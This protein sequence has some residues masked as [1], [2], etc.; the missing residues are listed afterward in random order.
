VKWGIKLGFFVGEKKEQKWR[1]NS[2]LAQKLLRNVLGIYLVFAIMATSVQLFLEFSNEKSNQSKQVSHLIKIFEKNLSTAMWDMDDVQVLSVIDGLLLN[3]EIIGLSI[4]W[5]VDNEVIQYGSIIDESGELQYIAPPFDNKL[6]PFKNNIFTEVYVKAFDI[7]YEFAGKK[8][9]VGRAKIYSSS[10]L[11]LERTSYTLYITVVNAALKTLFLYLVFQLILNRLVSLPLCKLTKEVNE[12]N[13]ENKK[14]TEDKDANKNSHELYTLMESFKQM[15]HSIQKKNSIIDQHKNKLEETV[16]QR[17]KE[18]SAQSEVLKRKSRLLSEQSAELT[19]TMQALARASESKSLFLA[20]MS[21]EIRTPLN[22]IMGMTEFL[23][24]SKLDVEQSHFV[25]V[26]QNSS[27]ALLSIINDI[28]D[29]SKIEAGKLDI[30]SHSFNI[31]KL[32]NE[33]VSLFQLTSKEFNVDFSCEFVDDIKLN[34]LGDSGR[35]RQILLNLLSNAFKFTSKGCVR[36]SV[37]VH[38]DE[39]NSGLSVI[40]IVVKDSGIGLTETQQQT[41]FTVFTQA[42]S[43]T[44]R[45]FGG[46]GLGLAISKKLVELMGGSIGVTS[47]AG[48]GAEF[49][50]EVKLKI[51]DSLGENNNLLEESKLLDDK[52]NFLAN[53]LKRLKVMVVEDNIVNQLVIKGFL[54]RYNI[55]PIVANDGKEAV[56]LF[57]N[58]ELDLIFMDCEM[59]ELDGFEASAEIRK[60]QANQQSIRHVKIVALSAHAL[61][62]YKI[63]A[64]NVGMDDYLSKPINKRVLDRFF[65]ENYYY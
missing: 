7:S 10:A 24:D 13:P 56:E 28:L 40:H 31:E 11:V 20:T 30:D 37:N 52:K 43:S 49:W 44:S 46:T 64:R 38:K 18:L 45:R 59:P 50:F 9:F 3:E 47:T 32:V 25:E 63:K 15:K 61:E 12:F 35:L 65:E 6:I 39:Q 19:T 4:I 14:L 55:S 54:K 17:T 5:D 29:F 8:D 22:G 42:D 23:Q 62:E 57:K 2:P 27:E 21:H 53:N 58:N 1:V 33:C 48:M 41:L 26:I 51:D 60:I 16:E 36:L 34:I